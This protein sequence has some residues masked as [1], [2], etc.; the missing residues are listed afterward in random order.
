MVF[1]FIFLTILSLAVHATLTPHLSL[2]FPFEKAAAGSQ[3]RTKP[4][5]RRVG[6]DTHSLICLHACVCR[7]MPAEHTLAP[8]FLSWTF[9]I[10][11]IAQVHPFNSFMRC[12]LGHW[13]PAANW[14]IR[15]LA[16]KQTMSDFSRFYFPPGCLIIL[17]PP[18]PCFSL[19]FTCWR[20][21]FFWGG[22]DRLKP[23]R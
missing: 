18:H 4:L 1:L 23:N 5:V 22:G 8:F 12:F 6:I 21:F 13:A 7:W 15:G 3:A 14:S 11:Q 10:G 20:S 2:P 9:Q 19:T 17:V 16:E